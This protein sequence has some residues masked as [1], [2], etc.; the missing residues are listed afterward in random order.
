[1][2][3]ACEEKSP[4]FWCDGFLVQSVCI[5]LIEMI[6]CVKSKLCVNYFIPGNKSHEVDALFRA[7][8]S[9]Q[10]ICQI[11]DE[12]RLNELT[13]AN[14]IFYI[15]SPAW[16]Q[17][18]YIIYQQ[19]GNEY[20]FKHLFWKDLTTDL[21]KALHVELSDIYRGL[22][23]HQTSVSCINVSDRHAYFLKS[24]TH[25]LLATNLYES[26]ERDVI[27]NCNKEFCI[28]VIGDFV[29][30][31][32]DLSIEP[33]NDNVELNSKPSSKADKLNLKGC[34]ENKCFLY[35]RQSMGNLENR[36]LSYHLNKKLGN[37]ENMSIVLY[38]VTETATGSNTQA[39]YYKE[40]PGGSPT[41]NISW[42]IANAY[43]ANLYYTTQRDASLTI[44][45]CDDVIDIYRQSQANQQ[46][47]ESTFPVMLSTQW[48]SIYDKEIE[49]VLGFYSLCSYVLDNTSSRSV[50]LGVCPVQFVAYVKLRTSGRSG[51]RTFF[52][53]FEHGHLTTDVYMKHLIACECDKKV[54][55]GLFALNAAMKC[56]IPMM[57]IRL[58]NSEA[59]HRDL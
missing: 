23:F 9:D 43:L 7:S 26:H 38:V 11:I 47:A 42:F 8:Q 14:A 10:L 59:D 1:M 16:I 18:A 48:T 50:Y 2:F 21:R 53:K 22:C 27:Y 15:K 54:N 20:S 32:T 30:C 39:L 55:N 58:F 34:S 6:K 31:Y 45:T 33:I 46:F 17:Q 37:S 57:K 19:L 25:L 51:G 5:L 56:Y 28:S 35:S 24:E 49:Q 13:K 12:C 36:Q 29:W 44:Q 3:W 52:G 4:Q 41:V 40:W